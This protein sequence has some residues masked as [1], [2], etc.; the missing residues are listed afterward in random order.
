MIRK[1]SGSTFTLLSG[2][3]FYLILTIIW[4]LITLK[5]NSFE[6]QSGYFEIGALL[7]FKIIL[8]AAIFMGR[9][10]LFNKYRLG[11]SNPWIFPI[12]L[13][14]TGGSVFNKLAG[15][16]NICYGLLIATDIIIWAFLIKETFETIRTVFRFWRLLPKVNYAMFVEIWAKLGNDLFKLGLWLTIIIGLAFFYLVSFFMVDALL[17]SYLLLTPLIVIGASL[18]WLIFNK[19]KTWVRGDLV[20]IDGELVEQLNWGQVRND[21]DLPQR[22]AWFQYLILIRDYLKSLQ[23]P[24]LLLK[25]F[26]LY[27]GC[28][29]LILSLPYFF[30]RVIEV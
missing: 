23:R 15:A 27:M 2:G 4:S 7:Q 10:L 25:T 17:Y 21:P 30:G 22:T 8:P 16:V 29:G 24:V 6:S 1:L 11:L 28:S 14:W 5:I 3:T 19:L 18:Y 20:A 13:F 12:C 26:L 9:F